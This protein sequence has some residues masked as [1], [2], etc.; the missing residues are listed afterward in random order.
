MID[1]I[2][3]LRAADAGLPAAES[4]PDPPLH[5]FPLKIEWEQTLP[6]LTEEPFP[7]PVR[8]SRDADWMDIQAPAPVLALAEFAR[9]H[10]WEVRTQYSRGSFP[11]AVTG[12]PGALKDGIGLRFGA[13]PM[14]RRQAYAVYTRTV[15]PQGAWT[16]TSVMIWG[17]DLPPF[18]GCGITELKTYLQAPDEVDLEWIADIR[19]V[20]AAQERAAKERAKTAPKKTGTREGLQ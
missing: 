8:T 16:W 11:H 5:S 14:T 19:A 6:V 1:P 18:G 13:H 20:R 15:K 7:L 4:N 10:S 9:R 17:P 2:T 3:R 12:R